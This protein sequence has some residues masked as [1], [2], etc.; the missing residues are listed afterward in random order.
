MFLQS[1]LGKLEE[2]R[3]ALA[4]LQEITFALAST[5]PPIIIRHTT[6]AKTAAKRPRCVC[7]FTPV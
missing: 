4:P 3:A 1:S 7:P 2:A 5:H 6:V